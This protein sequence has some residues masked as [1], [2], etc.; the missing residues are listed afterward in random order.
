MDGKTLEQ[1][2]SIL[3][4]RFNNPEYL[5]IALTHPSMMFDK[6]KHSKNYERT[7]LLGDAVLNL[8]MTEELIKDYPKENEGKLSRRRN[9]LV[10]GYILSEIATKMGIAQFIIMSKGEEQDGGRENKHTLENVMEA[11]IGAIYRD[12]GIELARNFILKHWK[13]KIK[14]HPEL[15]KEPKSDLQEL[16]QKY[17]KKLPKYELIDKEGTEHTPIFVT[18]VSMKNMGSFIGKGESKKLSEKEAAKKMIK[19]ILEKNPDF[20]IDQ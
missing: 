3:D 20:V 2:Y 12:G 5:R 13:G 8:I 6:K 18:K 17:Y 7:E 1:I 19:H 9:A 4:Y 11:L 10:S 14:N 15:P 16:T